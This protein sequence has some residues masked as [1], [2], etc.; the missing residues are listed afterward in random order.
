MSSLSVSEHPV[1]IPWTKV[2]AED[3]ELQPAQ[4]VSSNRILADV[5]PSIPLINIQ[6]PEENQTDES[7]VVLTSLQTKDSISGQ[8][9]QIIAQVRMISDA[10]AQQ[11]LALLPLFSVPLAVSNK[12]TTT[13]A[14]PSTSNSQGKNHSDS[15]IHQQL[16][17]PQCIALKPPPKKKVNNQPY[18]ST[19]SVTSRPIAKSLPAIDK[20]MMPS[21]H[22]RLQMVIIK[23]ILV[24]SWLK[25]HGES[26]LKLS[27]HFI[28]LKSF[29]A[30][31]SDMCMSKI[32]TQ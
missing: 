8:P 4:T 13:I 23:L 11:N 12:D 1:V 19:S 32:G 9:L 15:Q 31:C 30:S 16:N 7:P 28:N 5:N 14:V 29:Q 20:V 17:K 22:S 25:L 27:G 10:S 2:E 24:K 3:D 21:I 6:N 18:L 26:Q